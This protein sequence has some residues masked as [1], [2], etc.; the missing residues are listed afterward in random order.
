MLHLPGVDFHGG[1]A[2][3]QGFGAGERVGDGLDGGVLAVGVV[4]GNGGGREDGWGNDLGRGE[5]GDL[6]EIEVEGFE[7]WVGEG[8]DRGAKVPEE[9]GGGGGIDEVGHRAPKV[10][11][12]NGGDGFEGVGG[13]VVFEG[14]DEMASV[15]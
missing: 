15:F 11:G 13:S 1:L 7:G 10:G 12:W 6:G 8:E 14:L 5:G 3:E 4:V 9:G 2:V